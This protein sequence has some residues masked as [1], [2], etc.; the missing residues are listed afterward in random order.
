MSTLTQD[1]RRDA[2]VGRAM[3]SFQGVADVFAMYLGQRL[4]YYRSLWKD[5]PATPDELAARTGT[6]ERYTR[7]WLEQ[8]AASGFLDVDDV[9]E[10]PERRRFTLPAGHA[11][12]LADADDLNYVAPLAP[13]FAAI[14][15]K[16]DALVAAYRSGGGVSWDEFGDEMREAQGAQNKPLFL[17]ALAHDCLAAIPDIHERLAADAPARVAD[18][19]CGF[20][21]SS[22][23]IADAYPNVRVDGFDLDAPSIA[24]AKGNAREHGVADRVRFRAIDAGAAELAGSYDLVIICEALHDMS[25]PVD[26][27]RTARRL[28]RVGGAVLVID[29]KTDEEFGAPGSDLD[30]LF[31]GF[32]ILVCLPDGLSRQPSA[33]TG[34]VMRPATVRRYAQ[35]AGFKDAVP[36]PIELGFFR[37]YRL[38]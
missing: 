28:A 16:L 11:A 10:T 1:E 12:V 30:Q 32:S 33:A 17:S 22:I 36:L 7:E 15:R 25:R 20:G 29:E 26:V 27:L 35:E 21:W 38:R 23:G 24:A 5:G 18:I 9:R 14:G 3:Q 19:A 2:L 34:T 31:Y 8:Q 4:G 6:N 37:V 13:M